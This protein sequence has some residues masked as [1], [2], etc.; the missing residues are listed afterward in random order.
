MSTVIKVYGQTGFLMCL[1][2]LMMQI[3][4]GM[5]DYVHT[6]NARQFDDVQIADTAMQL[7]TRHVASVRK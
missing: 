4:V 1:V 3:N 7:T 6:E 5:S 2:R